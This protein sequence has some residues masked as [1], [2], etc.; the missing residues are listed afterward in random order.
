MVFAVG[1]DGAGD[2]LIARLDAR[3][4]L[5]TS[6]GSGGTLLIDEPSGVLTVHGATLDPSGALVLA[7]MVTVS[8]LDT[9]MAIELLAQ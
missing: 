8:G 6:F 4:T 5:D 2:G 1:H 9:A 7:G 3:G